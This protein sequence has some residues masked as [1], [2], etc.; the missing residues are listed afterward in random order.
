MPTK[1]NYEK[2]ILKEIRELPGEALPQVLK[3][4]RSIKEAV[5]IGHLPA[6]KKRKASGLCGIWVDERTA[7]EIIEDIRKNRIGFS[8]R[9][10]R[11]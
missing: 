5:A 6:E 2:V 4:L 1:T 8:G 3:I 10:V 7:E 9:E 11:L